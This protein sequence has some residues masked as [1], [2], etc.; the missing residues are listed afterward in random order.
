MATLVANTI[1]I[2]T[3]VQLQHT[4]LRISNWSGNDLHRFEGIFIYFGF[5]LLL[6]LVSD[7]IYRRPGN[8]RNELPATSSPQRSRLGHRFGL[9][10]RCLIP[11]LV[12]YATTL[13]IP[14]ANAAIH[15]SPSASNFIEHSTFVLLTPIIFLVP[16]TMLSLYRDW[17]SPP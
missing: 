10:R 16:I 11:L 8:V 4:P 1:R 2:A 13:G 7:G 15:R 5:L 3:A 12:Y 6:F 17:H 9:L 14:I